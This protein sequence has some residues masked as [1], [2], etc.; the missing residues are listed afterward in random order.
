MAYAPTLNVQLED[1]QGAPRVEVLHTSFAA[2]TATVT[3]HR[4]GGDR[5]YLVRGAVG[6]ATSGALTRLDWEVPFGIPVTYRTE[7]FN[8]AGDSLGFTD[9]T[10]VTVDC[11][12]TWV[13]NPL[14]PAGAVKVAFR[15]S[16]ARD[17]SRPIPG[18]VM[19]PLGRRVGVL[20]TGDRQGLTGVNLD[21]I[22]DTVEAADRIQAMLGDYNSTTIP[23]LC[24]RIG[25][26]D[27]VRL[28]RPL[29]AGVL[30]PHEIDFDYALGGTKIAFAMQGDEIDPPTPAL[31]IPLLTN[32]DLNAYYATNAALN[33]DNL[34]NLAVN[35]RYELAGFG[36]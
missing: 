18:N 21:I 22:V 24:F 6:A 16:A 7:M 3:T 5:D 30:D 34:T 32:A 15:R 36:S 29:F 25:S 13:H 12:D 9:S 27:R 1:D 33:S 2:G 20:V 19:R 35:R 26:N 23:A 11:A 14:D 17:L 28:P 31:F 8:T 4:L 10:T